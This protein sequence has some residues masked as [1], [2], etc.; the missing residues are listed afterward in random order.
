MPKKIH[1]IAHV[2]WSCQRIDFAFHSR[3][4]ATEIALKYLQSFVHSICMW[5][6]DFYSLEEFTAHKNAL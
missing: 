2:T 1:K 3:W 5:A 4:H 6:M